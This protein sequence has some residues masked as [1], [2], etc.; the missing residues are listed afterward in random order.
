MRFLLLLMLISASIYA[1]TDLNLCGK[2][3]SITKNVQIQFVMEEFAGSDLFIDGKKMKISAWDTQIINNKA[4]E[5]LC[6]ETEPL[7]G[8][9]FQLKVFVIKTSHTFISI[10]CLLELQINQQ[11]NQRI[12]IN[13]KA[14]ELKYY[15]IKGCYERQ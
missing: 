3:V 1:T 12:L 9:F 10:G 4:E 6:L 15:P 13:K 14:V 8:K 2:F 11:T 5:Y 7:D